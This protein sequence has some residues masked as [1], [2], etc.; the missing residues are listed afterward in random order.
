MAYI[1]H[2]TSPSIGYGEWDANGEQSYT[3]GV[4]RYFQ[5]LEGAVLAIQEEFHSD[6][7]NQCS[8]ER[9]YLEE[10]LER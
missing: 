10:S 7:I 5:T 2:L 8:I 3:E 4:D 6:S 1:Y 9:I